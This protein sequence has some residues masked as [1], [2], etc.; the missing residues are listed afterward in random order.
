MVSALP[1]V[2]V[3]VP[4]Y[5][6]ES[7]ITRCLGRL[8]TQTY[9]NIELILV[10]DGSTD[11]GAEIAEEFQRR[12]ENVKILHS[13]NHGPSA[14][15]NLGMNEATGEFVFFADAD[16]L[17]PERAIETLVQYQRKNDLDLVFGDFLISR[18]GIIP[19]DTDSPHLLEKN[20]DSFNR[21]EI[22]N[23]IANY[24]LRPKGYSL[25]AS[26]WSKLFRVSVIK[27]NKIQ[28]DNSVR[29]YEDTAFIFDYLTATSRCGYVMERTYI[30]FAASDTSSSLNALVK[31]PRSYKLIIEKAKSLSKEFDVIDEKLIA[32][33]H[34]QFALR[35]VIR[36]GKSAE[37]LFDGCRAVQTIMSDPQLQRDMNHYIPY[38][39]DSRILPE[40]LRLELPLAVVI[41]IRCCK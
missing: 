30:Y 6:S 36:I 7:F 16:D 29:I 18:D 26:V 31:A 27:E 28:F 23:I 10:D 4:F 17:V 41:Y 22:G 14:A 24:L 9:Q 20:V 21:Q 1:L 34:A 8:L 5:Q 25:F 13:E 37:S 40:L 2:S 11:R 3:I 12:H 32:N 15:R 33:A 19:G 38:K 35:T 39:G